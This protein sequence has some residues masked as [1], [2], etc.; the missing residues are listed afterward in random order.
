MIVLA[1]L[2]VGG[3]LMLGYGLWTHDW[4]VIVAAVAILCV[5]PL[6][7][8]SVFEERNRERE[9]DRLWDDADWRNAP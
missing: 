6:I 9:L 1:G 7:H 5:W 8:E 2:T 3:V 4:R